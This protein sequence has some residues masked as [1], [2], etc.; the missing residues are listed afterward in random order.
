MTTFL[1]I[2]SVNLILQ[3]MVVNCSLLIVH[4]RPSCHV[5]WSY[6]YFWSYTGFTKIPIHQK[7][8]P[9]SP[10]AWDAHSLE[11]SSSPDS[12]KARQPNLGSSPHWKKACGQF[13]LMCISGNVHNFWWIGISEKLV[14]DHILASC[15]GYGCFVMKFVPRLFCYARLPIL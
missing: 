9:D 10:K 11:I 13:W 12:E 1:S 15:A 8:I 3:L 4:W 6:R 2:F 5:A 14:K 7:S